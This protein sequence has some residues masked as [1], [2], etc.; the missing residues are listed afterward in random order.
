[1]LL[2]YTH[3]ITN[4]VRYIFNLVFKSVLGIE[5]EIT[6]DSEKFKQHRGAKFS[7]TKNRL[8]TELFFQSN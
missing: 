3:R 7:Y 2:I 6:T 1:M 8:A 5:F 4:R